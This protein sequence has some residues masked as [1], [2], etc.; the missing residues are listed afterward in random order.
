MIFLVL[1]NYVFDHIILLLMVNHH[2]FRSINLTYLRF[3]MGNGL[4]F[5]C[6]F[7]ICLTFFYCCFRLIYVIMMSLLSSKY[8][9]CIYMYIYINRVLNN[10]EHI[11]IKRVTI[12]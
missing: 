5:D 2:L 6:D 8:Y 1:I 9:K 7:Y 11:I 12:T 3:I 10:N 4:S